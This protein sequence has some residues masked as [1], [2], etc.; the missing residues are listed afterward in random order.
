MPA[1]GRWVTPLRRRSRP[2]CPAHQFSMTSPVRPRAVPLDVRDGAGV[3][4]A[5][6]PPAVPLRPR[7]AV[8]CAVAPGGHGPASG[9]TVTTVSPG[10]S[11]RS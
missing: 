9:Q 4:G 10:A 7:R 3:S 11:G 1:H 5:V 8:P 2:Q 6:L